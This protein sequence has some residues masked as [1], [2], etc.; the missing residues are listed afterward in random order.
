MRYMYRGSWLYYLGIQVAMM[1]FFL[2]L[3]LLSHHAMYLYLPEDLEALSHPQDLAGS[4]T[5]VSG[6]RRAYE[7]GGTT[8]IFIT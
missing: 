6:L 2:F 7:L 4:C 5:L 8:G 3:F 1:L